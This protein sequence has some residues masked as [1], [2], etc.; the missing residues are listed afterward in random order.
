MPDRNEP[1]KGEVNFKELI[2]MILDIGYDGYFGAEYKP[3]TTTND[4]L[5]WMK[6]I[7]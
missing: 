3:L 1:D 4:G 7:L 5:R 2:R 6:S